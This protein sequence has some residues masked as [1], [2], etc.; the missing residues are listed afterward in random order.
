M[1]ESAARRD[2]I[3]SKAV[4]GWY[5]WEA[6]QK[7]ACVY[8]SFDVIDRLERETVE[9]FRS[10]TSRGSEMGGIL[11]G[12]VVPG[13]PAS[14]SVEDYETIECDY[15]RGP[16]Y[17]LS[18]A[19]LGRFERA[20]EERSKAGKIQVVGFFRSHTRKGLALDAED[21][22]FLEARFRNPYSMALLVRPFAT[23]ASVG[24]IF[25]REGGGFNSEAQRAR[26]SVSVR[27]AHTVKTGY[28]DRVSARLVLR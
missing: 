4:P 7:P 15:S 11:L 9:N 21:L 2:R 8:L 14:I 27:A 23:K 3:D 25:L 16:L 10:L 26:V 1:A 28:G 20:I 6:P 24:G 13:T 18:D 12:S 19:D 17:R 5:L 22:Q